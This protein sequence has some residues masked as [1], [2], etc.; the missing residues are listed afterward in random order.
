MSSTFYLERLPA[1]LA[2]K[3]PKLKRQRVYIFPNRQGWVYALMLVVMLL[4]AI[5]YNNSMAFILCFLLA[6]LGI[7]AMLHTYRNLSG[8]LISSRPPDPVFAGQTALFPILLDNRAG[9]ARFSLRLEQQPRRLKRFG[10]RQQAGETMTCIESGELKQVQ[11]PC[12]T[13]LR[14]LIKPGRLKISTG[15]PLGI[16][17]AWSYFEPDDVGL[18]YPLPRGKDE[19]PLTLLADEKATIGSQSGMD[20]FAGFRKYRPGDPVNTIAWKAFAREQGLLIKQFSGRGAETLVFS[21]DS[22]AALKDTE[23]RLSQLCYWIILADQSGMHYGLQIPGA[24]IAP[25][26]GLK[27]KQR[28]LEQL[29]RYGLPQ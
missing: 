19:M 21:W 18:V 23:S 16:F 14:G 20:D 7:V 3:N 29:A 6:S 9:L 27:H 10:K 11:L 2:R 28:C 22:V 26:Y 4:G 12:Q 25:S 5:N 1:D 15:F 17:T 13:S 8:L 24:E